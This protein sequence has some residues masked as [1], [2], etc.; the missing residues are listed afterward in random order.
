MVSRVAF[1]GL[2]ASLRL[3]AADIIPA[4]TVANATWPYQ[5]Y[6][7]VNFT[8][9][10]L[11]VSRHTESSEG[12][13]FFAPDGATDF[14][15]APLIMDMNSE[16][17][18]NGPREHAFGFGAQTY[19][20]QQ[21]L[22]WWNGTLFPEP[23]GRGNGVVYM[24]DSS[25]Q[26]IHTIILT[27]NFLEQVPNATFS[28][29]IDVHEIFITPNDTMLVTANNVTRADLTSVGGPVDG[30]V[31]ACLV[32]EIDIASNR[33]LFDWNSLDHLDQLPFTDSLFPLGS[34]G[35]TGTSQ[36][37]AWGYFH[38]N[39]VSPYNGGYLI[40]SRYLCSAIAINEAGHVD[41]RLQGRTG[42]DF[43]LG[44]GTEFCYQH[45]I[46]AVPERPYGKNGTYLT[47][48]MHDNHNS[49]IDNGTA[50]SSGKS[51]KLDLES[52]HVSLV[53]QYINVTGPVYSAAQGSYQ[54][55]PDGNVFIGHGWIPVLEEFAASG[56]ILSIIQFGVA[57]ARSGG[58]FLSPLEPTLSYRAFKQPWVGCP[59]TSPAVVAKSERNGTTVYMSWNGATEVSS[60]E[61]LAWYREVLLC[62]DVAQVEAWKIYGGNTT[63]RLTYITSVLKNGFETA[64]SIPCVEYVEVK[65][66]LRQVAYGT[67]GC[68]NAGNATSG[69]VAACS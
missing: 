53:Q 62:A 28:S 35:L 49:P 18:W 22:V 40:S 56:E 37:V 20:G 29:N 47:L 2:M 66:L 17:V 61:R 19:K 52:R 26:L 10:H 50:P 23:V 21:V 51:L 54:P 11:E 58:G 5:A 69:V 39:A 41:W 33:V 8:P 7:T 60:I 31:V 24:Y 44:N 14:Q 55:L 25:Y 63:T 15:M 12:Y 27:G 4:H 45:D 46:R 38:I 13:L 57:V 42:G 16:L 36:D 59:I 65:P 1:F 68:V 43:T 34:Q 30:W 67:T 6:K 64:A 9:P 3:A 32:Y 48:H